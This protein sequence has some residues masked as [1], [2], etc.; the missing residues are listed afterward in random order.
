MGLSKPIIITQGD[1]V[2]ISGLATKA[3][4]DTLKND[5]NTALS[6]VGKTKRY[7]ADGDTLVKAGDL[8]TGTAY[9]VGI[10]VGV[11]YAEYDGFIKFEANY[12]NS[13]GIAYEVKKYNGADISNLPTSNPHKGLFTVG[14]QIPTSDITFG[15]GTNAY[16]MK[17]VY[18]GVWRYISVNKGDVLVW[19]L[20]D[21][22][23]KSNKIT[24]NVKYGIEEV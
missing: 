1:S 9:S 10:I 21:S 5:V 24:I 8:P 17:T 19:K 18:N 13:T 2:D 15:G 7:Y 22:S 6:G 4:M 20:N 14:S 12:T 16:Y 3:D 11:F 23:N